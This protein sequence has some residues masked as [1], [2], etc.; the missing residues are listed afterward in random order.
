MREEVAEQ[1]WA[2]ILTINQDKARRKAFCFVEKGRE[3][4]LHAAGKY[5]H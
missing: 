2:H 4:S 5:V 3:V 1:A